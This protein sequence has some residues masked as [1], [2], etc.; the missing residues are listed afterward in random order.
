MLNVPLVLLMVKFPLD[1]ELFQVA[2]S[3]YASIPMCKLLCE[4]GRSCST[5]KVSAVVKKLIC[6]PLIDES[7]PLNVSLTLGVVV[8]IPMLPELLMIILG[9]PPVLNPIASVA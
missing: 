6:G 9:L 4:Y 5:G 2:P 7:V 1:V 8:P 3:K